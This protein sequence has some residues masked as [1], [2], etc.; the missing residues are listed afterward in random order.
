MTYPYTQT[1]HDE[2]VG[3]G[4]AVLLALLF[5]VGFL[6]ILAAIACLPMLG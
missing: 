6:G 1:E 3:A 4:C 5:V 2:A